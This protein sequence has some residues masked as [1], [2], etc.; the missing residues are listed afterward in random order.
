MEFL[1]LALIGL[2][3]GLAGGLFGVGGGAVFVPLLI[4]FRKFSAHTAIATS[5]AVILPVAMAALWR[6]Q[7]E[8][9][10]IWKAVPVLAVFAVLGSWLGA[11]ISI[12]TGASLLRRLFAV[13]LLVISVKLFLMR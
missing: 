8:N 7:G 4:I 1:M 11:G 13:Y 6:Y 5:L 10:V 9:M 12:Q 2:L 3:G